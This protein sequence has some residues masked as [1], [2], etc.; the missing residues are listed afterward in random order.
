MIAFIHQKTSVILPVDIQQQRTEGAQLLGRHG[1]AVD[2]AGGA[3]KVFHM[4]PMLY[5]ERFALMDTM[6]D[7]VMNFVG[8]FLLFVI[9]CFFPYRHRGK[10]DINAKIELELRAAEAAREA[11]VNK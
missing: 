6:D 11:A 2:A 4:I 9:L 10:N 5:P 7:I 3:D 8:G 1:H